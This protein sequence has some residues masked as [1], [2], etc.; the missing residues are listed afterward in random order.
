MKPFVRTGLIWSAIAI[1]IAGGISLYTMLQLPEG[2]DIP[3]HWGPDGQPDRFS[4]RA[5]ALWLVWLFPVAIAS[6]VA[7]FA[8]VP[9]IDPRGQNIE[10]GRK[11]YLAIWAGMIILFTLIH[12]GICVMM[13]RVSMPSDDGPEFARWVIAGCSTLFILIGNFLPKTRSSFT[14]GIRTPWTLSSDTAWE[15]THRLAGPLFMIAG[16]FGAIG[17]FV[18]NG[19]WLALQLSVLVLGVLII[20]SVYSYFAWR[21][22]NDRDEGTGLTI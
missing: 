17:A 11:A 4:S 13:L 19:I 12:V 10:A 5:G 22:A 7:I 3:V 15:K 16:F 2:A 6:M 20:S 21:N 8:L 9:T 14:F 1:A 18:F